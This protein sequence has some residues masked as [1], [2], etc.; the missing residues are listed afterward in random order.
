MENSMEASQKITNRTILKSSNPASEY[1]PKVNRIIM[2]MRYMHS[3]VHSSIIHNSQGMEIWKQLKCSHMDE[4]IEKMWCVCV[5]VCVCVYI[6]IYIMEYYLAFE[7]EE[8]LP[9]AT[10]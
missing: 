1:I 8:I 10:V 4:W 6:Y 5:C 7:K 2:P 9:F 3:Y